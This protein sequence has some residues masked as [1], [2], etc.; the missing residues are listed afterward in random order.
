MDSFHFEIRSGN[1]KEISAR[2]IFAF[3]SAIFFMKRTNIFLRPITAL[4]SVV[5]FQ[6]TSSSRMLKVKRVNLEKI[7]HQPLICLCNVIEGSLVL[8]GGPHGL[9]CFYV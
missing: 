9:V 1:P 2:K 4:S 6:K 8:S 7:D 5:L 3:L